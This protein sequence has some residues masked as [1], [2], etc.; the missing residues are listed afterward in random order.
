MY[1]YVQS[2]LALRKNHAALRT[3]KQWHIRREENDYA[4]VRESSNERLLIV[5]NNALKT[6]QLNIPIENTLLENAHRLDK[7]L[8][9]T[10]AELGGGKVHIS[11]PPPGA[12]RIRCALAWCKRA[13]TDNFVKRTRLEFPRT[14]TVAAHQLRVSTER[15]DYF[16]DC[17][18]AKIAAAVLRLNRNYN[19]GYHESVQECGHQRG[20]QARPLQEFCAA[21]LTC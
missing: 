19:D 20:G 6:V 9:N 21:A 7:L 14:D 12:S 18:S 4:F 10:S 17:Q 2:L 8:G 1:A 13:P 15:Q 16:L 11:L 5:Y 3:G